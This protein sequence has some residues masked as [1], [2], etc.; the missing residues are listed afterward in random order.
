MSVIENIDQNFRRTQ[1]PDE[2]ALLYDVVFV[3]NINSRGWILEKICNVIAKEGGYNTTTVYTEGNDRLSTPLPAARAYFFSH[4]IL[5]MSALEREPLV[6][7]GL[8]FVW[9]THPNAGGRYSLQEIG[10]GLNNVTTVFTAN[11]E[12]ARLIAELGVDRRKVAT[13]FGGADPEAFVHKK[14][15][16]G[17]VGFVGAYYER[18]NPDLMLEVIKAMPETEFVLLG[19]SPDEVENSG[20]LWSNWKR[21]EELSRQSNLHVISVP[22]S[23]YA[24]HMRDI[25]VYVSLS[26]L[27]GGPIPIVEALL[28]NAIP[29]ATKTGFAEDIITDGVNGHI[30]EIECK[31]EHV[32]NKIRLAVADTETNVRKSSLHLSWSAFGKKFW[33]YIFPVPQRSLDFSS[34][35]NCVRYCREGFNAKETKGR[36]VHG[37]AARIL[38]PRRPGDEGLG[39]LTLRFQVKQLP[40]GTSCHLSLKLNGV[41]IGARIFSANKQHEWRVAIPKTIE[42]VDRYALL[43]SP[44]LNPPPAQPV[45]S[46][47]CLESIDLDE[48]G[49]ASLGPI[50]T[51]ERAA[52]TAASVEGAP[53]L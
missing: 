13:I 47:L 14:R 5:Y 29:I 36:N 35:A 22:Y 33:D 26:R 50:P 52:F 44:V 24:R 4:Y 31:L 34:L 27:E 45:P 6:A 32:V 37:K 11:S 30:L 18:K 42:A 8:R 10:Y 46:F 1:A 19:P 51:E 38:F 17:K 15:G 53:N 12:H 20:L 2:S 43:L 7:S 25:D 16:H 41:D 28:S 49:K 48:H 39:S 23:Q 3:L 40:A 21:Y 9:F